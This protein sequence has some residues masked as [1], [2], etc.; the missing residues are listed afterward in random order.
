M[1]KVIIILNEAPTSMRSWNGL[2]VAAGF[3]GVDMEVEV[4]LFDACVYAAIRGQNP[5]EG[6]KELNLANKLTELMQLGIKV[7]ACG[8][9]VEAAGLKKEE[10]VDGVTVCTLMDLCKSV[11]ASNNVLVF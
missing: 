11:K 2:R 10:L 5:P 4:F 7:N 8:T 3:V 9:C 1:E 6:L